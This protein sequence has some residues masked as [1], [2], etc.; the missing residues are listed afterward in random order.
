MF[1]I[2]TIYQYVFLSSRHQK[3]IAVLLLV[4]KKVHVCLKCWKYFYL[5]CGINFNHVIN[6][7]L[8]I[9]SILYVININVVKY[10]LFQKI[11]NTQFNAV[12][13][14]FKIISRQWTNF[15]TEADITEDSLLLW[16][17]GE[18]CVL[19]T[20]CCLKDQQ[21]NNMTIRNNKIARGTT[22]S[23]AVTN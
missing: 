9:A 20:Y 4:R 11:L 2:R 15:T 1:I 5:K 8:V 22:T 10:R 7:V 6:L 18:T 19:P 17:T 12:A 23:S 13:H 3:R 16:T 14:N 21:R